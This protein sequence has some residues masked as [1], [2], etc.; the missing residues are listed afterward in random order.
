MKISPVE[1]ELFGVD[2]KRDE[3]NSPILQFCKCVWKALLC[4]IIFV[5]CWILS[6]VANTSDFDVAVFHACQLSSTQ[7]TKW[8]MW[9][10][11]YLCVVMD[12]PTIGP[13][14]QSGLNS[15][16]KWGFWLSVSSV[17]TCW[18]VQY[19]LCCHCLLIYFRRNHVLVCHVVCWS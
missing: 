8:C 13:I 10:W 14:G 19:C 17:F 15:G 9:E 2:C 11:S 6:F 1:T 18:L 7:H 16:W 12:A 4:V 5:G 3:A